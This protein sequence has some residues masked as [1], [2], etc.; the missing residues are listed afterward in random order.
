VKLRAA[1]I[2]CG[3]AGSTFADDPRA[4]GVY[5]H[6]AAYAACPDTDLVAVCDV[7]SARVQ[8]CA[9]RWN[10]P[11]QYD[12]AATLL[13]DEQPDVVSI[14]T[15]DQTHFALTR[16]ALEASSTRGVLAE[17][18]LALE[19]GEAETL[20]HLADQRGVALAVNYI[21]RFA[22]THRDVE[23]RI[24]AG[25]IGDIQTVS[26][27]YTKGV[28]HNGTHWFDLARFLVGEVS[29]VQGFDV[30]H[31]GHGDPTLDAFLRFENGAAG[32]LHGCD[33]SA[34]SLFEM[35]IVGTRGRVAIRDSGYEIVWY[36]CGDSPHFTGFVTLAESSR[37]N[38]PL[39]DVTLHAVQDLVDSVRA[40]RPPRCSGADGVRAMAIAT[41]IRESARA[42]EPR[43]PLPVPS[44]RAA[45][46]L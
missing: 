11:A 13:R 30:L 29:D 15:P 26:G 18:P 4:A 24:R 6:A 16:L 44:H 28:V 23:Q 42:R 21:R 7:D 40:T 38:A 46:V 27:F 25:A 1:V 32:H 34:F 8:A 22:D 19:L 10:V 37:V 31:D 9:R 2:G 5:S 35:D 17:K 14:C 45:P 3:A 39:G 12:D 41:A 36:K 43:T 33:A 20:V